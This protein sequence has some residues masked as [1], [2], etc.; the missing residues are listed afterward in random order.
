MRRTMV[1]VFEKVR[2]NWRDC[3]AH[4]CFLLSFIQKLKVI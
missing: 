3:N 4:T 1:D 2:I